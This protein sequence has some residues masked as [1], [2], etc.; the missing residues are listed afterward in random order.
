MLIALSAASPIP[1]A[2]PRSDEEQLK[3]HAEQT[4]FGASAQVLQDAGLGGELLE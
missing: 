1:P 4:S 2:Q 3:G